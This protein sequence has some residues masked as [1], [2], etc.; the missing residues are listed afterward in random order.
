MADQDYTTQEILEM[1]ANSQ[2]QVAQAIAERPFK[3]Y[4]KNT[5][6]STS[7]PRA[8]QDMIKN[9]D[10]I[11]LASQELDNALRPRESLEYTLASALSK[12]PQQQGYGSWLSDFARGLG[13]GGTLYV[14]AQTSRAQQKYENEM[15]DLAQ[16]LAYDKAMG[17]IQDQRQEQV[18]GYTVMPYSTSGRGGSGK[19]EDQPETEVYDFTPPQ[20]PEEP[21][22]W[23][24]VDIQGQRTDPQSGVPTFGGLL[25]KYTGSAVESEGRFSKNANQNAYT[26]TFTVPAIT[27]V[28][29][30]AGGSRGIDT[31]PEV[32]IKGGP[33]LSSSNMT[34]SD[35]SNAVKDQAW[36]IADQIIKANP[37]ATI[38]REE[39]ANAFINNFNH[40]LRPEF[41]VVSGFTTPNVATPQ[42]TPTPSITAQPSVAPVM[43]Y[44]YS[45]YGFPDGK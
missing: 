37:K 25:A 10:R 12:V 14:D 44:D 1:L 42:T 18:M 17:D 36:D 16:I 7:T 11:R 38:T 24:E 19:T 29:K 34:T 28:A 39:L 20:M 27:K 40:R 21:I 2:S 33:E 35:F 13:A 43:Q 32:N 15:R 9:R 30:A 31:M 22:R 8:L 41:R 23:S 6:Y 45:K 5:T 3:T 4:Q 26:K